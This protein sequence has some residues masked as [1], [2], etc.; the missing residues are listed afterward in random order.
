[1]APSAAPLL[2]LLLPS[3]L[4]PLPSAS[5]MGNGSGLLTVLSTVTSEASSS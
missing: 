3:S 2:P 5:L 1:V 4:A